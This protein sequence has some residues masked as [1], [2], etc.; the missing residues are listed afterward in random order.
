MNDPSVNLPERRR[1]IRYACHE[2]LCDLG[3]ALPHGSRRGWL[4]EVSADGAGLLL[5]EAVPAGTPLALELDPALGVVQ[6]RVVH[7][8]ELGDGAWQVGCRFEHPLSD[9]D[10]RVL[11]GT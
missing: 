6:A 7:S 4:L 8:C 2:A 1:A 11:A 10:L 5:T 3:T 9:D